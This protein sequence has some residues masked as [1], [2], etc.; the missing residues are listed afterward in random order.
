MNKEK[1]KYH[2]GG[3]EIGVT[4]IHGNANWTDPTNTMGKDVDMSYSMDGWNCRCCY[5]RKDCDCDDGKL[6]TVGI[7]TDASTKES[8]FNELFGNFYDD[9]DNE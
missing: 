7:H 1:E 5:Y 3:S 4:N 6:D 9:L 8:E 2:N